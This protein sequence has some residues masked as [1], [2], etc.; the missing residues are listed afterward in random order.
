MYMVDSLG[1]RGTLMISYP[2]QALWLFLLAGLGGKPNKTKT[3]K[4]TVAASFMLFSFSYNGR[5]LEEIDALF[6]TSFNPFRSQNIQLSDAERRIGEL[7]GG[8]DFE[9]TVSAHDKDRHDDEHVSTS[10]KP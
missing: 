5:A 9:D 4:S 1:R 10:V 7:E 3:E 2:L 6:A 8:K